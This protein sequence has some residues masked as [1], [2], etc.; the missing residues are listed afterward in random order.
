MAVIATSAG[1]PY[2]FPP[3][4]Y[5]KRRID[6]ARDLAVRAGDPSGDADFLIARHYRPRSR[7]RGARDMRI[8]APKRFAM[9]ANYRYAG[10]RRI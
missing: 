7:C 6:M 2:Y 1:R 10:R 4:Q 3:H 9:E 8:A 5:T